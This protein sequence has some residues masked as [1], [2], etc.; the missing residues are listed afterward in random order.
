MPECHAGDKRP[1]REQDLECPGCGAREHL[2]TA[3]LDAATKLIVCGH[4]GET[5]K[6]HHD[7]HRALLP[8]FPAFAGK[9]I[10]ASPLPSAGNAKIW[11][12]EPQPATG[13]SRFVNDE[14]PLQRPERK[15]MA[16]PVLSA[17]SLA[18]LV[19]FV[20]ARPAIV[21]AAPDLAS[22]YGLAGL[23]VSAD[24]VAFEAVNVYR[25]EMAGQN[26]LLVTGRLVSLDHRPQALQPVSMEIYSASGEKLENR[27]M[28]A[29]APEI[30][31]RERLSFA[32]TLTDT[33]AN[34]ARI[35]LRFADP[36]IQTAV[37]GS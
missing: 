5:W 4:C 13:R 6:A 36:F 28:E 15:G 7:L 37:A 1:A 34:A 2:Q 25:A 10:A 19:L 33:P 30:A 3:S 12:Q 29:P 21:K 23:H 24:P 17:L 20:L 11:E 31:P 27:A 14:A 9:P 8:A 26:A 18:F 32:Y 16:L 22:L 35:E